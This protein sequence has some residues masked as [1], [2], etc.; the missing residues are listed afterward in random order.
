MNESS[1][2]S[3][4]VLKSPAHTWSIATAIDDPHHD[5]N[6]ARLSW[7]LQFHPEFDRAVTSKERQDFFS[8]R[9]S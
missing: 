5:L 8:V 2:K 1:E 7:G 9:A 3:V 6:F 4:V